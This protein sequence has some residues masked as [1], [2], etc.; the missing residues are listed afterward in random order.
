MKIIHLFDL[1]VPIIF[2]KFHPV[3]E[4]S[5]SVLT[6]S[7]QIVETLGDEFLA[8]GGSEFHKEYPIWGEELVFQKDGSIDFEY[9]DASYKLRPLTSEERLKYAVQIQSMKTSRG[10]TDNA[11]L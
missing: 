11:N 6:D 3:K 2:E 4:E 10:H 9:A 7:P 5:F 8:I 1:F